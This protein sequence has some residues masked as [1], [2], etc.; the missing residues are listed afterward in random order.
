MHL[1]DSG[2]DYDVQFS[3]LCPG[4]A[5]VL[6]NAFPVFD[7]MVSLVLFDLFDWLRTKLAQFRIM[8][9]GGRAGG[10]GARVH[11]SW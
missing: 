8:C 9:E 7:D 3:A 4:T 10:E 6:R 11:P 1:G 2:S 5:V